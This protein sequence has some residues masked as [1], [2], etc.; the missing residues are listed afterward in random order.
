MVISISHIFSEIR[1]IVQDYVNPFNNKQEN[2]L[3]G[4]I[5]VIG[6]GSIGVERSHINFVG[7]NTYNIINLDYEDEKTGISQIEVKT[8]MQSSVGPGFL[9]YQTA[10]FDI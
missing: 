9:N 10:Y 5:A 2:P 8:R 6:G 3:N 4:K 7:R 1:R